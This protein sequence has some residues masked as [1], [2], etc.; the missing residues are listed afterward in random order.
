MCICIHEVISK[1]ISELIN[2][3]YYEIKYPDSLKLAKII[4]IF[5]SGSKNYQVNRPDRQNNWKSNIQ[6]FI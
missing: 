5:K 6:P 1:I 3:A 4:P 2:L